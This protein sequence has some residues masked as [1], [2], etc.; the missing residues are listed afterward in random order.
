MCIRNLLCPGP[1]KPLERNLV[2]AA[3][4]SGDVGHAVAEQLG[5]S[6]TEVCPEDTNT[7]RV[8]KKHFIRGNLT[9]SSKSA[10]IFYQDVKA[11]HPSHRCCLRFPNIL[12]RRAPHAAHHHCGVR[13]MVSHYVNPRPGLQELCHRRRLPGVEPAVE[14]P[15]QENLHL[16]VQRRQEAPQQRV[17][18]AN[19]AKP[20]QL[21]RPAQICSEE[22]SGGAVQCSGYRGPGCCRPAGRVAGTGAPPPGSRAASRIPGSGVASA[23]GWPR[24]QRSS[25]G[26]RQPSDR[27]KHR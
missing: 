13:R 2:P 25:R 18:P 1:D 6:L 5:E 27:H 7:S 11:L 19:V 26:P 12:E 23:A 3:F 14:I 22:L 8:R 16:R 9:N 10:G 20:R 21:I 4:V 17:D 24:Y 15:R